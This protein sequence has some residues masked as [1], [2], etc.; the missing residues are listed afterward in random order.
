MFKRR[1][2]VERRQKYFAKLDLVF[3]ADYPMLVKTVR[4]CLGDKPDERPSSSSLLSKLEDLKVQIEGKYG[5]PVLNTANILLT[6]EMSLK[7]KIIK[8]LKVK[9]LNL[10]RIMMENVK[11]KTLIFT[12][13]Q[14]IF[15]FF[16]FLLLS[17]HYL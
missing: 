11:F 1:S 10:G 14:S 4:E 5:L 7:E 15:F 17:W 16:F 3:K 12:A 2:E 9:Y 13:N 8:E 6:K